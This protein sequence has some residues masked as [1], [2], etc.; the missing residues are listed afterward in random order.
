MFTWS[1]KRNAPTFSKID[2]MLVSAEWKLVNP[3]YRLHAVSSSALDHAPL[4]LSR[5]THSCVKQRFR[6]ELY[7]TKLEGFEEAVKEAQV[8]NDEIFDPFKRLDA[9]FR[10]TATCL[11]A[12]GQRKTGNIKMLMNVA[13][14]MIFR[15]NRAQEITLLSPLELSLGRTLKLSLLGLAS[16]ECTIDRQRSRIRWL[17]DGDANTKLFQAVD[18]GRCSKNLITSIKHGDEIVTDQSRKEEVFNEAFK[19][20]LG[21]VQSRNIML[22]MNYHRISECNLPDHEQNFKEDE[23]WNVIKEI[24]ADRGHVRTDSLARFT[25]LLGQSSKAT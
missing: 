13:N 19:N 23:I 10:N 18:N 24:P 12:W 14:R 2:R 4:H 21:K 1:N 20:L 5:S 16:L 7:W 3:D 9:L 8:C 22:D 11:Q 6:F 15:L 17:K 25:T